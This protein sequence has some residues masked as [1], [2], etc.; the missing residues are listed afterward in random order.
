MTETYDREFALARA[1]GDYWNKHHVVRGLEAKAARVKDRIAARAEMR[2]KCADLIVGTRLVIS[3]LN[4]RQVAKDGR[5]VAYLAE[6]FRA[7]EEL[8][9]ARAREAEAKR[10]LDAARKAMEA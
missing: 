6:G 5:R 7:E 3:H 4:W 8:P 2:D 9:N 1:N 10:V